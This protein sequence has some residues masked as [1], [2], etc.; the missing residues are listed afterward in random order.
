LH[1]SRDW[2]CWPRCP[3]CSVP[4]GSSSAFARCSCSRWPWRGISSPATRGRV[5][6]HRRFV[7]LGAYA[8]ALLGNATGAP[9]PLLLLAASAVAAL[10]A[11]VVS[12]ACPPAK[13]YSIGSLAL[14]E[15]LRILMV[16]LGT[17]GGA[18]G[19]VL[20]ASTPPFYT[21]Y[22]LSLV[23]ALLACGSVV[24]LLHSPASLALRAVRDDEDVARQMGV[25][26]FRVKLGA[27]ALAAFLTGCRRPRTR[28]ARSSRMVPSAWRGRSTPSPWSS[29]A[30]SPRAAGRCWA[31]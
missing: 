11:V 10:F 17:F 5:T 22:W 20:E 31:R 6:R 18:S 19:I 1:C 29:S 28:P 15:A 23:V 30:A 3:T 14:T 21:L 13:L 12:L 26:S 27:F 7:G 2:R 9:L 8:F 24:A 25:R 16:N 4:T